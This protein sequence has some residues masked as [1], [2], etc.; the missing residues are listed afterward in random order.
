[1]KVYR[2]ETAGNYQVTVSAEFDASL[3]GD[4]DYADK[5]FLEITA[6]W[7]SDRP[8]EENKEPPEDEPQNEVE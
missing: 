4:V 6:K 1:M 3:P 7:R 8:A 2:I 5:L